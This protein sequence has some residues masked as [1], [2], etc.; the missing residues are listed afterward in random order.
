MMLPI[1][2]SRLF[3]FFGSVGIDIAHFYNHIIII[4]QS[5]AT[6]MHFVADEFGIVLFPY[7]YDEGGKG[8]YDGD[9]LAMMMVCC[10]VFRKNGGF[11]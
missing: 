1:T 3:F 5:K 11:Y 7:T 8:A 4:A 10:R 9:I 2:A 6:A